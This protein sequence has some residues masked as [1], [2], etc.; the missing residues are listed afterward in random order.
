MSQDIFLKLNGIEGES[1]DC[2]HKGEIEIQEWGWEVGQFSNM[3]SGSG[4]GAGKCTIDDLH[5]EHYI[6]K[7][8][9][10][11]LQYCLTGKHISEA[12][13]T[14][15]K[16]GGS[17][18]DYLKITLEEII[19]THVQP[20]GCL[21]MHSPIERIALS[22]SRVRMDYIPQNAQG[23]AMGMVSMGYDIKAN[24]TI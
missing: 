11:L 8:S 13:L 22:F 9:P 7:S 4:G 17:P 19:I 12:V 21:G 18:L 24:T 10:N 23:T 15:R 5:F 1:Q 2:T 6:D 20:I 3:H 16:A 14:I